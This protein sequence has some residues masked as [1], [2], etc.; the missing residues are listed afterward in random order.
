MTSLGARSQR[1]RVGAV[2]VRDG[3]VL[4]VRERRRDADGRRLGIEYW[5]LPGGGIEDGESSEAAVIREVAEETGLH[6][7][8]ARFLWE[9]GYPS[10]WTDAYAVEI[11]DAQPRLGTDV[12]LTCDCPR[13][14]GLD[15]IALPTS[16]SGAAAV[17]TLL[18]AV[19]GL[20]IA[21]PA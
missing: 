18:V 15:W 17:P 20:G 16:T 21:T 8:G 13:M 9:Y 14:V 11:D 4:M 19:P 5:T 7:T 1:R 12:D 3:H 6:V 2:I 10:G